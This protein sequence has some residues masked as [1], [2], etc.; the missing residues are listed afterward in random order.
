MKWPENCQL[1][2][3]LRLVSLC[4]ILPASA[5]LL[6][7]TTSREESVVKFCTFKS[8]LQ[9]I[10]LASLLASYAFRSLSSFDTTILARMGISRV[11]YGTACARHKR[12]WKWS[13]VFYQRA[14]VGK[15]MGNLVCKTGVHHQQSAR[16]SMLIISGCDGCYWA[17]PGLSYMVDTCKL[18]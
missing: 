1:I 13:F 8:I 16:S 15:S 5:T 2:A 11:M 4:F 3:L 14:S 6:P 10:I 9:M 12:F 18:N 7:C 17:N